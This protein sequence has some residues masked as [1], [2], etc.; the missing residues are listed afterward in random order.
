MISKGLD[1]D[2]IEMVG[3]PRADQL[4]YI[5][6]FRAEEK[7]YQLITQLAGRAGRVSGNG[8]VLIQ[9][10]NPNHSVFQL[11]KENDSEKIYNYFLE[12]R[13]KFHYPPFTKLIMIELKHRKEDKVSRASQFMGS[14]LRKYLPEECVFGPEKSPI[15]RI[16]TLYQYQILLKLP[17]GK[18]Y[19]EYKNYVL[20]SFEE[21]DEITAYH[22]IKKMIFVD[23]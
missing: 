17:R 5:Q 20:K 2:H 3:I 9:T 19:Q 11:I 13:Q 1:F 14:V 7:A 22:S 21:F 16:N 10:F 12:E 18:N 8:K 15:A 23:F 6:D 4:V